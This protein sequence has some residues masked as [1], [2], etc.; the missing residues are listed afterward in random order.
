MAMF[1]NT[2]IAWSVY[3]L[4]L[5]F[6]SVV[7]WK[8]CDNSWN[9]GECWD[10]TKNISLIPNNS[11]TPSEEF[12]KRKLLAQSP[13]MEDFGLPKWDLILLVLLVWI[14]IYFSI[15]KGVKSTGKVCL[16]LYII[17]KLSH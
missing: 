5:S 7:P 4:F 14:I 12:F 6:K 17:E 9:T 11:K 13:S 15:W 1:Y 2:V 16:L 8:G 10:G 3:Y